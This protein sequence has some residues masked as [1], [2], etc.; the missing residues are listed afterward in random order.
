[1][2]FDID[3]DG[4]I[5]DQ[6]AQWL[7]VLLQKNEQQQDLFAWLAKSPQHVQELTYLLADLRDI[8][9]LSAEDIARIERMARELGAH[10]S[11]DS[12]NVVPLSQ[13]ALVALEDTAPKRESSKAEN[14]APAPSTAS[15]VGASGRKPHARWPWIRVQKP[16]V[17]WVAGLAAT[18]LVSVGS[19]LWFTGPGSWT[20][21]STKVGE[22]RALELADGSIV[23]LNTDSKIAVHLSGQSRTLRLVRGEALFSVKHDATRPFLVHSD[24]AVIQ[25]IGTSFDVY[26][27]PRG[28]RVSVIEGLVQIS[29]GADPVP[30]FPVQ[31]SP[32]NGAPA[33]NQATLPS[34]AASGKSRVSRAQLLAAGEAAEVSVKGEVSHRETVDAIKAVAWRQRRLVFE[35]DTLNDI[36]AEFN[37]YN[38]S[39]KIRV[40]GDGPANERFTATFDADAPEAVM[41]A[42]A[43]DPMLLIERIGNEIVIQEHT[44]QSVIEAVNIR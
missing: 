21:Y 44:A 6:A 39:P 5:S 30:E 4:R 37:R 36:A 2:H 10:D 20:T 43:D 27:R 33:A 14:S 41:E 9:A 24:N 38:A 31:R 7:A 23:H 16:G 12:A 3:D 17:R 25:A 29:S 22:Q 19:V 18:V 1:M 32:Q 28:T 26:R 34:A 13:R 35:N 8:A 11:H 15:D 42:L 40:V